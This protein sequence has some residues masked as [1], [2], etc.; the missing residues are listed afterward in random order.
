MSEPLTGAE[1]AIAALTRLF[2]QGQDKLAQGASTG[3]ARLPMSAR[4][5]PEYKR[6]SGLDDH[7]AFDAQIREAERAGAI[8]ADRTRQGG[9]SAGWERLRLL[10]LDV[11]AGLLKRPLRHQ[12]FALTRHSL[13]QSL[14]HHPV[15]EQIL[16]HWR[17]GKAVRGQDMTALSTLLDATRVA[18][19]A[20][21]AGLVERQLRKESARLFGNSKRIEQL[22]IWLD[23][24]SSGELAATGLS[25]GEI[26]AQYGLRKEPQPLLLS[27]TGRVTISAS[28]VNLCRPY[29]G[30]PTRA[31]EHLSLHADFLLSIENLTSFHEFIA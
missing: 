6:L 18:T 24:L 29:L 4:Y 25:D 12:Q 5:C 28:E 15:I 9:D 30:L 17:L 3:E 31:L 7:E 22:G 13:E 16:E 26:W 1:A 23:I 20:R 14:A 10:D 11:L 27:G 8:A 19:A 2:E 21:Q